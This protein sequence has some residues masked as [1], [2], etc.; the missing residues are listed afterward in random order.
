ML[1]FPC[2]LCGS[3]NWPNEWTSCPLCRMTDDDE[4]EQETDDEEE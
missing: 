2:S 4:E 1:K 3:R